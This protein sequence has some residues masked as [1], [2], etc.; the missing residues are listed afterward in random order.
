ML[1]FTFPTK[2]SFI[3]HFIILPLIIKLSLII[4]HINTFAMYIVIQ[5]FTF[6]WWF[7]CPLKYLISMFLTI[8]IIAF[9]SCI[10]W[11]CFYA[12]I[13]LSVFFPSTFVLCSIYVFIYNLYTESICFIIYPFSFIDITIWMNQSSFAISHTILSIAFVFWTI[14]PSLHSFSIS[15][16]FFISLGNINSFIIQSKGAACFK[17]L[18]IP[19]E[20]SSYLNGPNFCSV[21]LVSGLE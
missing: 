14:R 2:Y 1:P 11:P 7:I 18:S 3:I 6:I 4:P 16:I 12:F 10:I 8:L 15:A 19:I 17:F 13:M 21:A 5:E 9:I 20:G